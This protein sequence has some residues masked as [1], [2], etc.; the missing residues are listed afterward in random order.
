[1]YC[2]RSYCVFK[3]KDLKNGML[4]FFTI[5]TLFRMTDHFQQLYLDHSNLSVL[6]LNENNHQS[7]AIRMHID[8]YQVGSYHLLLVSFASFDHLVFCSNHYLVSSSTVP[9]LEIK[10]CLWPSHLCTIQPL[11]FSGLVDDRGS[12]PSNRI[13]LARTAGRC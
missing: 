9:N 6:Y 7:I 11:C 5:W 13:C 8:P 2:L 3:K 12:P 1:M 4:A 10:I